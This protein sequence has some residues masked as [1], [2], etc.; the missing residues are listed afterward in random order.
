MI[1][2]NK[3]LNRYEDSETNQIGYSMTQIKANKKRYEL[4]LPKDD[5]LSNRFVLKNIPSVESFMIGDIDDN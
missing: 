4:E 5:F 2:Y 3:Y 1:T